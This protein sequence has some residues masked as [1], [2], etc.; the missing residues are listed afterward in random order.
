MDFP[1]AIARLLGPCLP[2]LAAPPPLPSA[3]APG[4]VGLEVPYAGR[5]LQ[6]K[7]EREGVTGQHGTTLVLPAGGGRRPASGQVLRGREGTSCVRGA[8]IEPLP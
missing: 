7:K 5:A 8:Y 2:S 1:L 3:S 4:L 6:C